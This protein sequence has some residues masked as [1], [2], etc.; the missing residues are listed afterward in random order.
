MAL[1]SSGTILSILPRVGLY[2]R[3]VLEAVLLMEG[4]V[5]STE[6]VAHHLGLRNRFE[7]DRLLRRDGLPSLRRITAWVSV[8]SWVRKSERDGMSLCQLASR[9]HRHPSACYRLVKE[10]SGLRWEEVRAHGSA[11]VEGQLLRECHKRR[12]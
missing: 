11:W 8:L 12:G 1:K 2:S 4:P 9:S 7:L 3:V 10:I 5:G 6:V